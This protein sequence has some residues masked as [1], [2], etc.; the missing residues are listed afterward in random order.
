MLQITATLAVVDLLFPQNVQQKLSNLQDFSKKDCWCRT[1]R[2]FAIHFT[3]MNQYCIG[4]VHQTPSIE[5]RHTKLCTYIYKHAQIFIL[6]T[7]VK[8][9]WSAGWQK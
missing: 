3:Q 5:H 9:I 8:L 7:I 6:P 2:K 1:E 4:A